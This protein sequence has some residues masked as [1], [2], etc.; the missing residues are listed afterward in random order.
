MP[1][2]SKIRAR[3]LASQQRGD[4]VIRVLVARDEGYFGVPVRALLE[5]SPDMHYIGTL[6]FTSALPQVAAE[7]WPGVIVIG[8]SVSLPIT[9]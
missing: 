1:A 2:G 3:V 8:S 4:V 5:A 9:S 6:P 7:L